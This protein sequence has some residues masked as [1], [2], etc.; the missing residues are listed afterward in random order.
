MKRPEKKTVEEL[1]RL[2]LGKPLTR[3]AELDIDNS[4]CLFTVYLGGNIAR[5]EPSRTWRLKGE[6]RV[7]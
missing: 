6:E 7:A 3:K 4:G 2:Y 5:I 1:R